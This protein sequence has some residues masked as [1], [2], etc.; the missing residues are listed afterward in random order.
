MSCRAK[1]EFTNL[2]DLG[3]VVLNCLSF[4]LDIQG[5]RRTPTTAAYYLFKIKAVLRCICTIKDVSSKTF[6]LVQAVKRS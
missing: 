6:P 1:Q 2:V 3:V 4:N 5:T